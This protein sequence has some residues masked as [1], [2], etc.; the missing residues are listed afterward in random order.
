MTKSCKSRTFGVLL[1][2]AFLASP[3]G[4]EGPDLGADAGSAAEVATLLAAIEGPNADAKAA[5]AKRFQELGPGALPAIDAKLTELRSRADQNVEASVKAAREPNGS[6][7]EELDLTEA[8]LHAP[9]KEMTGAG[10]GPRGETDQ[11]GVGGRLLA[12]G[13]RGAHSP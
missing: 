1:A 9:E 3:A 11:I 5:A 8:L 13:R 12:I 4:A 10:N 6:P 2:L 7:S